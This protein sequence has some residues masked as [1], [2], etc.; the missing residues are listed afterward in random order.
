MAL[1]T[2][3]MERFYEKLPVCISLIGFRRSGK[4]LATYKIVQYLVNRGAFKRIILFM[5]S[6]RCNPELVKLVKHKFDERL[7][8]NS[9]SEEIIKKIVEQ[10]QK[11]REISEDNTCLIVFD[12]C[13]TAL[14]RNLP[15]INKIFQAGRHYLISCITV[16]V[17]WS[18]IAP[19]CRRS[20][21]F[22]I[23]YSNITLYDTQ[24]L[25]RNFL[26]KNLIQTARYALK[27]NKLYTGLVIQTCPVQTLFLLKF[28]KRETG[29]TLTE[30]SQTVRL[31]KTDSPETQ[32]LEEV[33]ESAHVELNEKNPVE[34]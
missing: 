9:F 7:I 21:D 27:T 26:N 24:F 22:A 19:S 18:D 5:G 14:G 3:E 32:S 17:S 10:Q 30:N 4:S 29:N 12:D 16:C 11:L 8:F 33:D 15:G 13:Y 23:L 28:K 1:Q 34:I 25:T 31:N 2:I 20:L 6:E